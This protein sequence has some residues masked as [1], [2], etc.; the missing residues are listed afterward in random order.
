MDRP[1]EDFT[2]PL[3]CMTCGRDG[4]ATW[5]SGRFDPVGTSDGFYLR[6]KVRDKAPKLGVEIVCTGCGNIHHDKIP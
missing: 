5:E 3:L 1:T 4:T 6:I 2:T